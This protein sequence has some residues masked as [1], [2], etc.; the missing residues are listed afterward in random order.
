[1]CGIAG[2]SLAPEEKTYPT[3]VAAA[4][5]REIESR[6]PDATGV[7]FVQPGTLDVMYQ[8]E[9]TKAR[10][11]APRMNLE[12]SRTAIL[13]TRWATKGSFKVE[14]NNHPIVRPGIVGVHNGQ[15]RNDDD[16]FRV[17]HAERYGEVDSEAIFA[18]VQAEVPQSVA[19]RLAVLQ[20]S[21]AIAWLNVDDEGKSDRV[22]H[23]ARVSGS[24]LWIGQTRKGST[25]F[26][27]TRPTIMAGAAAMNTRLVFEHQVEEGT[28][29]RIRRGVILEWA[30]IPG[31][32]VAS[33]L[34]IKSTSVEPRRLR[35]A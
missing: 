6:G 14:E 30:G 27:S 26:G 9:A 1:M 34:G 19:E 5:L 7:A 35:L 33:S 12:G 25:L 3:R 8:K 29:F 21:A 22:L 31:T 11:F 23:L 28:Y 18:L 2:L 4:M 10:Y 17:L 24:P 16:L 20:G 15:I 13:H 32:A